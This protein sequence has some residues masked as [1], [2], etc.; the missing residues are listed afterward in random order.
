MSVEDL[1]ALWQS[2]VPPAKLNRLLDRVRWYRH[3]WIARRIVEAMFTIFVVYH[4]AVYRGTAVGHLLFLP[5][6]LIFF[7][8]LWIVAIRNAA[9]ARRRMMLGAVDCLRVRVQQLEAALR[10][11]RFAVVSSWTL[12]IYAGS[13]EW[14][15]YLLKADASWRDSALELF[16]MSLAIVAAAAGFSF[17]RRP[18]LQREISAYLRTIASLTARENSEGRD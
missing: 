10:E 16:W 6:F 3:G 12:L 5:I 2:D 17:W 13:C 18:R 9:V 4:Y 14:L 11:T 8:A 1:Q 15:V 7:P